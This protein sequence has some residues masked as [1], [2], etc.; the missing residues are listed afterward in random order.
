MSVHV[1]LGRICGQV[2]N[3]GGVGKQGETGLNG[4]ISIAM[5]SGESMHTVSRGD[6]PPLKGTIPYSCCRPCAHRRL[7]DCIV[8]G[9]GGSRRPRGGRT[10]MA[11]CRLTTT[12]AAIRATDPC[13]SATSL[14]TFAI[15]VRR[16]QACSER[17]REPRR[18]RR[19]ANAVS[20]IM[21]AP[22]RASRR[23][24]LGVERGGAGIG[25]CSVAESIFCAVT[26]EQMSK[27]EGGGGKKGVANW[28]PRGLRLGGS[29]RAVI[30]WRVIGSFR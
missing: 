18:C 13:V 22:L 17:A 6:A 11:H 28:K 21:Q 2:L 15:S 4:S 19:C 23:T 27:C 20:D 3:C 30:S 12:A 14:R 26:N 10:L 9:G 5:E 25:R 24:W 1:D 8:S 7:W 29:V 16:L